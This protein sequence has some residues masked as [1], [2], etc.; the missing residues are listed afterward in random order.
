M[1]EEV[2]TCILQSSASLFTYCMFWIYRITLDLKGAWQKTISKF[3]MASSLSDT[4]NSPASVVLTAAVILGVR[5]QWIFTGPCGGHSVE[6]AQL[7][8][9]HA[10]SST[11]KIVFWSHTRRAGGNPRFSTYYV[12]IMSRWSASLCQNLYFLVSTC[13]FNHLRP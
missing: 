8:F 1:N 10:G 6:A 7:S 11:N 4:S 13:I 3:F 9:I 12:F 2:L 5:F